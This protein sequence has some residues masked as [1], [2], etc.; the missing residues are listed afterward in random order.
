MFFNR[1][2]D[3]DMSRIMEEH[4]RMSQALGLVVGIDAKGEAQ[5][6][7]SLADEYENI[8][9]SLVRFAAPNLIATRNLP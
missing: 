6:I 7:P 9:A 2:N 4:R 8:L 1:I 5:R 3:N